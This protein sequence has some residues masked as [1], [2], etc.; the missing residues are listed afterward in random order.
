[1][2]LIKYASQNIDLKDIQSVVKTLKNDFITQGPK[3]TEFEK[4][5]K[6]NLE[7]NI[8]LLLQVVV[9]L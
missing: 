5:L 4:K 6:K 3:V 1:M 8:A 2:K 9:Q 7:R